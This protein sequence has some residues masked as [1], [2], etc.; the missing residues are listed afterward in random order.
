MRIFITNSNLGFDAGTILEEA[1]EY[2]KVFG[3]YIGRVHGVVTLIGTED[4]AIILE[5]GNEIMED[6]KAFL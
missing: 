5:D 2:S 3:G 1:T 6:D 4:G